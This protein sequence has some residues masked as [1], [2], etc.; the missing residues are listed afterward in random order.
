MLTGSAKKNVMCGTCRLHAR[1]PSALSYNKIINRIPSSQHEVTDN[2]KPIL[3]LCSGGS[4]K[5]IFGGWAWP[6]II[7]EAK[8]SSL[9]EIRLL[10]RTN[11]QPACPIVQ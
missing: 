4:R 1:P 3:F 5:K 7:W 11:F 2:S 8:T 6:L 9:R 10:Y